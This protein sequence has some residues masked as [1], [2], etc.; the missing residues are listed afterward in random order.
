MR[1]NFYLFLIL[2]HFLTNPL[3]STLEKK[4]I[5]ALSSLFALLS[6]ATILDYLFS[7]KKSDRDLASL[8]NLNQ[9]EN[10]ILKDHE[11]GEL[12]YYRP[13]I[14]YAILKN[15]EPAFITPFGIIYAPPLFLPSTSDLITTPAILYS[16]PNHADALKKD[17]QNMHFLHIDEKGE[18][19]LTEKDTENNYFFLERKDFPIGEYQQ[20]LCKKDKYGFYRIVERY[21]IYNLGYFKEQKILYLEKFDIENGRFDKPKYFSE[22][23]MLAGEQKKVLDS[24]SDEGKRIGANLFFK[25]L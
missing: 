2:F 11:T 1:K 21:T 10:I 13:E 9:S 4:N 16:N 12:F 22:E 19:L 6:A 24:A 17:A 23:N 7:K 18:P 14:F 5:L 20:A 3:L 15:T 25:E 8:R